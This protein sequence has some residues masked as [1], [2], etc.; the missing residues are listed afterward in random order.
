MTELEKQTHS[1]NK[2]LREQAE[3]DL[4]KTMADFTRDMEAYSEELGDS[5]DGM[6]GALTWMTE[7][8]TDS[9]VDMATTAKDAI[10]NGATETLEELGLQLND[11]VN[12]AILTFDE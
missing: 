2:E 10:V 7:T 4:A 3:K 9:I 1:N 8:G 5:W 6:V 11:A 12:N